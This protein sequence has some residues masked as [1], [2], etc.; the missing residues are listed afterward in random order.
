[1]KLILNYAKF[2]A[3]NLIPK[4]ILLCFILSLAFL[5][6]GQGIV[7][8]FEIVNDIAVIKCNINGKKLVPD[9][10][11]L[12]PPPNKC[13]SLIR[14]LNADSQIIKFIHWSSNPK[15]INQYRN[16]VIFNV[17]NDTIRG[18]EYYL[19]KKSDLDSNCVP[20]YGRGVNAIN[21]TLGFVTM[22]VKLRLGKNFDFESTISLGTTAG[23]KMRMSRHYQNYINFLFGASTSTVTL[24]S[25][26]T[27]GKISGQP[28]TNIFVFSPSIGIVV[29]FAKSQIGLF[30]GWDL[31]GKTNNLRYEWVYNKK[32]WISL[33]FGFSI[34]SLT[35]RAK[36]TNTGSP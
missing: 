35:E 29:E 26:S 8:Y 34:F 7:K 21:F 36:T 17:G 19:I 25:F 4:I 20:I 5:S 14:T 28:V 11:Y 33:G 10:S 1:M 13:F 30:Y 3:S 23:V 31:L 12:I 22:P 2:I 24:D 32:P 15:T 9:S 18:N 16:L 27:S 6:N